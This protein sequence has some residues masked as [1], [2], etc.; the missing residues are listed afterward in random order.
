MQFINTK[1]VNI[2]R[3]LLP[4]GQKPA[5]LP[6]K[7]ARKRADA[8]QH[9][10]RAGDKTVRPSPHP[11]HAASRF[12]RPAKQLLSRAYAASSAKKHKAREAP[13]GPKFDNEPQSASA[14]EHA[15]V[16]SRNAEERAKPPADNGRTEGLTLG[17]QLFELFSDHLDFFIL[18][19]IEKYINN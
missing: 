19:M 10:R 6:E 2:R 17:Q 15:H 11:A 9:L 4:A 3:C 14:G 18:R 8:Q 5:P 16:C 12:C 1:R 13:G 7:A